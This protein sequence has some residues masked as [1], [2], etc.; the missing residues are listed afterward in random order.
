MKFNPKILK[1]PRGTRII[2]EIVLTREEVEQV[3]R[4]RDSPHFGLEEMKSSGGNPDYFLTALRIYL[5]WVELLNHP[6]LIQ[7]YLP[8]WRKQRS[9]IT[10]WESKNRATKDRK[11]KRLRRRRRRIQ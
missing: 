3:E 9:N 2:L 10:E 7:K 4:I 1:S 5:G 6:H 11:K 8:M